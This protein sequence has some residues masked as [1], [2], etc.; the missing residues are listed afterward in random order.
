MAAL[1]LSAEAQSTFTRVA[2]ILQSNCTGAGCHGALNP[3]AFD[4]SGT[5][6]QVYTALVNVNCTN[7]AAASKGHKLVSPGYPARSFLLRKIANG[8]SAELA[9]D[10]S[11]GDAC[12]KNAAPLANAEIELVRQWIMFGCLQTGQ[13][14]SEQTLIDFYSGKALP[15]I[16]APPVPPEGQGF[17]VHD[18]PIFLLP[19]EEREFL[20]KYNTRLSGTTEVTRLQ[21]FLS[22]QSHHYI[23][24]KYNPGY[25]S[26]VQE[27]HKR[28][29]A[30]QDQFEVQFN[31]STIATWQYNRDHQLPEGTAYFWEA[32]AVLSS[33]FHVRN[34]DNDSILAAHVYL[35]VYTQPYGSGAV[36]MF[37]TLAVYGE[38]NPFSLTIPN[39]GVNEVISFEQTIPETWHI[40][41]LQAHTHKLGRD[42]DVFLRNS[43]GSKGEQVYEGWF[44]YE[45]NFN[46]GYYDFSHP[47]VRE[48]SPLLEV[49]MRQGLIHEATYF[50]DGPAPVGFGLTTSDEMFITYMH[51]TKAMPT[52]I[53][54]V[55]HADNGVSIY[56]NPVDGQ[57][58]VTYRMPEAGNVRIELFDMS[59]QRLLLLKSERQSTGTH[60]ET[61]DVAAL[62]LSGGIYVMK[63]SSGQF[64]AFEKIMVAR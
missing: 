64:T 30:L 5:Q 37:S 44:D 23:L 53:R 21:A 47:P 55:M 12:P 11:E 48:F 63:I 38:F 50:N 13:V 60:Q 3:Q 58:N 56:P 16:E 6:Q 57:F 45:R 25:G 43:N 33:N 10:A 19:G 28:V 20:W 32:G 61:F 52:G 4:L 31:A 7:A 14:V 35:N 36:E 2:Q 22:P 46:R 39:S 49:D 62:R 27:G 9:L 24:Y 1:A 17:Q 29:D 15:E 54:D 8:L 26:N 59:G 41:I 34:Y 18:G 51:Y 42:Y 40:W